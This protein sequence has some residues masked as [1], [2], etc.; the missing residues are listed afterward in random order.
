VEIT[1][2][3]TDI[4]NIFMKEKVDDL[5][6]A[7]G[8]DFVMVPL[9]GSYGNFGAI[10]RGNLTQVNLPEPMAP[11]RPLPPPQRIAPLGKRTPLGASVSPTE[12]PPGRVHAPAA[13]YCASYENARRLGLSYAVQ[14][15]LY[16]RCR[17]ANPAY[18]GAAPV[19]PPPARLPLAASI[20]G[21]PYPYYPYHYPYHYPY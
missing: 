16:Q 3:S 17:A 6:V 5:R 13:D 15:A 11:T 12:V 21:N 4:Q 2:F 1:G 7:L 9:Q 20:R 18:A 14:N 10:A 19:P 8:D